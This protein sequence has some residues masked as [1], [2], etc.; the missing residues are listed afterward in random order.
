MLVRRDAF[1][2]PSADD[3]RASSRA[4]AAI[5]RDTS[6]ATLALMACMCALNKVALLSMS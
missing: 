1:R 4:S 6:A 5:A 2:R 3:A